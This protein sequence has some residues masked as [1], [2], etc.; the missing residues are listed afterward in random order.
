MDNRAPTVSPLYY[1]SQMV[2]KVFRFLLMICFTFVIL[3]PF[4]YSIS[5]AFRA[6]ADVYDPS[7]IWLP[8]HYSLESFRLV[9]EA[10][11]Y[12]RVLLNSVFLTSICALLQ[13][14]TCSLVGYGFGRYRFRLKGVLFALVILTIVVPPQMVALPTFIQFKDFDILGICHLLLGR[15]ITL[16]DNP[17]SF[18]LLAFFGMGIRSG[19][20]ILIFRQSFH[21]MPAEL[22]DAASV[23]GC[24]ALRTYWR[25]M[26]PN[27]RNT[28]L[29]G[30]L[31]SF[32]WY[33]NDYYMSSIYLTGF[34][35]VSTSLAN[36]KGRLEML[37]SSSA[38]F[39]PYQ[40]VTMMQAGCLLTIGF[41]LILY[42]FTQKYF[43]NGITETG[44]VG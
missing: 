20:F 39:D 33:W 11:D 15:G 31:F 24:G 10:V 34:P 3:Y 23:D 4:L 41:L 44:I 22:E 14:F 12:G 16:V 19:L 21:A 26:I 7:V 13:L 40:I 2:W 37:V 35:T 30:F 18:F 38:A 1:L 5:M 17:A 9:I 42:I 25:I 29:M 8:R 27:A 28:L 36:L 43:T 6:P 32:V